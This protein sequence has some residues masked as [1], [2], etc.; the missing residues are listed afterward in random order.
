MVTRLVA[1]HLA[2]MSGYS[3][4]MKIQDHLETTKNMIEIDLKENGIE[5]SLQMGAEVKDGYLDKVAN[6]NLYL[7]IVKK[8][9][10]CIEVIYK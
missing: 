5:H 8:Q 7:I 6:A 2:R 9:Y 10:Q 3:G 4:G 1:S